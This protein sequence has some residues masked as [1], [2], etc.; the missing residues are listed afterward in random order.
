MFTPDP[1]PA[2]KEKKSFGFDYWNNKRTEWAKKSIAKKK[3]SGL[4]DED[5]KFF[6]MA[7]ATL[8]HYCIECDAEIRKYSRWNIHHILPKSKY[9]F[10]RHDIRNVVMLCYQHHGEAESA[11]SYPKMKIYPHCESIK[12]MLLED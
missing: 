6:R 12:K 11:I 5:E 8:P 7:W 2:P 9:P 4:A 1:K 10:F 3:D